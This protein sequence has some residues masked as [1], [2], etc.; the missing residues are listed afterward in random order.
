MVTDFNSCFLPSTGQSTL[1]SVLMYE[2]VFFTIFVLFCPVLCVSHVI[3]LMEQEQGFAFNMWYKG[4]FEGIVAYGVNKLIQFH[5]QVRPYAIC[6]T[7][8]KNMLLS[9]II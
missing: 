3:M 4:G 7:D 5:Q 6:I 1:V 9:L 8:L 2:Q